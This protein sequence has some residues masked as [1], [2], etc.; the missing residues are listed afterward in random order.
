MDKLL[1]DLHMI[2]SCY[3]GA[4]G[5]DKITYSHLKFIFTILHQLK[6]KYGTNNIKIDNNKFGT[7]LMKVFA[8]LTKK[9]INYHLVIIRLILTTLSKILPTNYY[10]RLQ[11]L[12]ILIIN[13]RV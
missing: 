2:C 12:L 6:V 1:D 11:E 13:F 4:G 5:K 9:T 7:F 10:F 8:E 3:N